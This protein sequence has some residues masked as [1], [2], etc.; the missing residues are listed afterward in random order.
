MTGRYYIVLG[1][2]FSGSG[3]IS[4]LIASAQDISCPLGHLEY[5][6]PH[7]PGGIQELLAA[8]EVAFS[9]SISNF[10]YLRFLETSSKLGRKSNFFSSGGD[11]GKLLPKYWEALEILC[12]EIVETDYEYGLYWDW[13][14]SNFM[15]KRLRYRSFL[16]PEARP[17]ILLKESL[18]IV[19]SVRKFHD[20]IF[21][22][23][24]SILLNQAGS[25]WNPEA[26]RNLFNR[27]QVIVVIRDPRDQFFEMKKF[28][29]AADV[30]KFCVWYKAMRRKIENSASKGEFILVQFENA[31]MNFEQLKSEVATFTNID[32]H[33]FNFDHQPSKDNIGQGA[34]FLDSSE[35][36][37]LE[38]ELPMFFWEKKLC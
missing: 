9:N 13:F 4:D 14:T 35:L 3:F 38:K 36:R 22:D 7:S 17:V 31:V 12:T 5:L 19:E 2:T 34:R 20:S 30:E 21:S 24:S 26:T 29:N 1:T 33:R 6:L 23:G 32:E 10:A 25:A 37:I 15:R 18:S 11:Y 27:C 16:A 8:S 28:K